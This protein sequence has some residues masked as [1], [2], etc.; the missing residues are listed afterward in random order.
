MLDNPLPKCLLLTVDDSQE[1]LKPIDYL[2][3]LYPERDHV[4][5]V[6]SYFM[7]PLAPAYREKPTSREMGARKR[8]MLDAR[9]EETRKV[10]DRAR[11]ALVDAG[12]SPDEI[13]EHVQEKEV[14]VAHHA[15]RLAD[16]KKVDA[17]VVQK[18]VSSK[19]EGFLKG[20][21]TPALLHHCLV[22]PVWMVDGKVNPARAVVSIQDENASLRALDHAAFMLAETDARITVLH[23]SKS[24]KAPVES[25]AFQPSA[26][27]EKWQE[28]PEGK[29]MKPFLEECRWMVEN[30]GIEPDRMDF[31]IVPSKGKVHADIQDYC[32]KAEAGI[33]VL[34]HSDPG[35]TWGFLKGS[36]TRKILSDFRNMAV[37]VCQ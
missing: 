28:T 17:V 7:P 21:P 3:R 32:R 5:L 9:E 13:Q 1:S 30:A 36:V 6:L 31:A 25:E 10:L 26:E 27:L 8:A 16:V 11:Q 22:S 15:C 23:A 12:F 19:L 29:A 18:R 37:W 20:D 4:S 14:S 34:G 33:L 2:C 35:G 24:V